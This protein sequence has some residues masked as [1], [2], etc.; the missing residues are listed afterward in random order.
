MKPHLKSEFLAAFTTFS[1]VAYILVLVP[2]LLSLTGMPFA[3]ALVASALSAAFAT[4]LMGII[5]KKPLALGP[6][7]GLNAAFVFGIVLGEG[8]S[9]QE[10]LGSAFISGL[11]LL[12]FSLIGLRAKLMEAIP[13]ALK[14]GIAGGIGLFLAF[15]GLKNSGLV[16]P[17]ADTL[18]SLAP[19]LALKELLTLFGLV[20]AGVLMTFKSRFSFLAVLLT[21]TLLALAF[22]LTQ[23]KGFFAWPQSLSPLFLQLDLTIHPASI[24]TFVFLGL[25]DT[26]GALFSLSSLGGWLTKEGQLPQARNLLIP[27]GLGTVVSSLLG[28]SP[29]SIFMESATGINAG[30]KSGLTS[31]FI[32]LFF[33]VAIFFAP[34]AASIPPLATSPIL[35]LIGALIF[36][37]I[38]NLPWDSPEELIPPFLAILA[39]PLTFSIA[40]GMGIAFVSYVFIRLFT[41]KAGSVNWLMWVMSSLFILNQLHDM[42]FG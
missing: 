10:A 26:T 16:V 22:G 38:K 14:Q 33:L 41:G 3:P 5:G 15:I 24:L 13:L 18:L 30:A 35:I 31:L 1:S 4:L 25:L 39:I 23:W 27:D 8:L 17:H 37:Q 7:L 19:K 12:F 29:T 28:T 2:E 11:I 42:L 20:V 32:A 21:N 6:G 34:L 40:T 9:W 36:S